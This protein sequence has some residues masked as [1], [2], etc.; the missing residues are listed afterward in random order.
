MIKFTNI[1]GPPS[2][3]KTKHM[4][5]GMAK[6]GRYI[7]MASRVELLKEHAVTLEGMFEEGGS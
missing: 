5:E 1:M 3:G 2:A 7:L 4:L 6:P